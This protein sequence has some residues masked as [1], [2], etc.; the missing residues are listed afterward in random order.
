[1]TDFGN[2]LRA[3]RTS[4]GLT[5][6][7]LARKVNLSRSTISH[8]ELIR[9]P[10]YKQLAAL[11]EALGVPVQE[12]TGEDAYHGKEHLSEFL[13]GSCP[14]ELLRWLDALGYELRIVPKISN[15]KE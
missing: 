14:A 1:M 13:L 12:L 9:T 3:L 2:K 11:A 7:D 10:T 4:K 5:Q 8:W 6:E 15:K